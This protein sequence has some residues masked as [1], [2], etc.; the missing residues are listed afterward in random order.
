MSEHALVSPAGRMAGD[1]EAG[2][3]QCGGE[4]VIMRWLAIVM[5]LAACPGKPPS[6]PGGGSGS[7]EPGVATCEALRGKLEQLYRAEATEREPK[8]V[9]EYVADNTAMVLADCAKQGDVAIRCVDAAASIAE[10]E[11]KCL[12]PLDEEGSEGLENRK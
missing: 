8:R 6:G 3:A 9:D 1:G 11:S 4:R 12:V 5:L 7:G 10:I 2:R